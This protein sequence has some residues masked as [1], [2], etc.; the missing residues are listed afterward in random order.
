MSAGNLFADVPHRLAG[1]QVQE[2]LTAP[3]VTIERIV[4]T[5]HSTAA[6]RWYDQERAECVLLLA[7]SAGLLFESE[8]EPIRLQPG[9]Y[10]HI[11]A[12]RRHRVEWTDLAVPTVRLAFIF[13][14]IQSAAVRG[15]APN[16]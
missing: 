6:N 4:S 5:G 11:P 14:E 10:V 2:L 1:E 7:G 3:N 16:N 9:S 15:A 13:D 8:T 12:R